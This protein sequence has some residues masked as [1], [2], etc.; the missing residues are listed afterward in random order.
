M[1]KVHFLKWLRQAFLYYVP[2]KILC[3]NVFASKDVI[4]STLA[5]LITYDFTF[6]YQKLPVS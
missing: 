3:S 6:N 1:I 4:T 2:I 5:K